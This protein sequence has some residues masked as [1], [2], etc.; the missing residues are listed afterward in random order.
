M[1]ITFNWKQGF[2]PEKGEGAWGLS[3]GEISRRFTK[4]RENSAC[5]HF[6]STLQCHLH[7]LLALKPIDDSQS[8]L[9]YH[10]AVKAQMKL[11]VRTYSKGGARSW[12]PEIK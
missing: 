11:R 9:N 10:I 2:F 4:K 5:L 12:S 1:F 7:L 8:H 6:I 3:E